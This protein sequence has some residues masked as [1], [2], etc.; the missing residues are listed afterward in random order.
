MSA[1][2]V[3]VV[4]YGKGMEEV[5]VQESETAQE[6][7][8]RRFGIPIER[9]SLVCRGKKFGRDRAA[10]LELKALSAQGHFVL[11]IGT[12]RA[13]Q[14]DEPRGALT[15]SIARVPVVGP[16]LARY[17]VFLW[18]L[19]MS[20]VFSLLGFIF[21][22]AKLEDADP[23]NPQ[24]Y[25]RR[26]RP[27]LPFLCVAPTDLAQRQQTPEKRRGSPTRRLIYYLT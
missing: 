15:R 10:T 25:R 7:V 18:D 20:V 23:E 3:L 12:P 24:P 5:E 22:Q 14:L 11:V 16:P 8:S 9:L 13:A 17:S 4:K 26:R 27:P 1:S 19:T 21:P 6:A 2:F